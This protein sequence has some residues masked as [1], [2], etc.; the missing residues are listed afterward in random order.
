MTVQPEF[1]K[2]DGFLAEVIRTGRRKTVSVRIQDGKASIVVPRTLSGSRI[3]SLLMAG[4][5][6]EAPSR[7][8]KVVG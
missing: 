3:E 8:Q 7:T 1:V 6:S 2:G 4:T 5:E